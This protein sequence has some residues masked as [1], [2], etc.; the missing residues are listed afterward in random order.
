MLKL[1]IIIPIYNAEK[2]L[3]AC[4]ASVICNNEDVEII[5]VDDGSTDSSA[6][7]YKEYV[8]NFNNFILIK[9][10]NH[11]V[12][13]SRNCAIKSA[14]G[15]YI[16]FVDADDFLSENWCDSV[17]PQT[18]SNYDLIVFSGNYIEENAS[19]YEMKE[20]CLGFTDNLNL[21]KCKL[22]SA[23]SKLYKRDFLN[24]CDIFF[25][26]NLINGEDMLFNFEILSSSTNVK[27]ISKN[28]YNYRI[29]SLSATN[30]FNDKIIKSDV[31]FHKELMKYMT[32]NTE[33]KKLNDII[34][35][36][37]L[38]GIYIIFNRISMAKIYDD[39]IIENILKNDI[40][41]NNLKINFIKEANFPLLEKI[42]LKLICKRKYAKALKILNCKHKVKRIIYK[43]NNVI[44]I[45]R[46]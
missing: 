42:I 46:I 36:S 11:G 27:F 26:E 21:K 35:M 31:Q 25:N 40:Y 37:I 13:F 10:D 4:L 20:A 39:N 3:S 16:M 34:K 38:N 33:D 6:E 15:K 18:D 5:L 29:N 22:S 1:S 12:S 8:D 45:E 9:N 28:I 14:R 44:K 24:K 43:N 17:M 7:I 19:Y 32:E 41:A 23:C 30:N 2:F